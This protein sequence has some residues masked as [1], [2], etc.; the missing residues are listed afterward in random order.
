MNPNSKV[1]R[2]IDDTKLTATGMENDNDEHSVIPYSVL[3]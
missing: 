1:W 2:I 3:N